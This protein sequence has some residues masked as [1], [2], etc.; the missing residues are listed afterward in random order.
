MRPNTAFQRSGWIGAFLSIQMQQE[1]M[2]D[3]SA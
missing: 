1:G 3:L 2:P